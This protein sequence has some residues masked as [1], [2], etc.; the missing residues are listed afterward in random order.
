MPI[1]LARIDDRVIHGQT[2]TRWASMRPVDS[3]IVISDTV[4]DDELRVRVTKSAA[5][6]Y[7]VGIYNVEQGVEALQKVAASNK[8]FFIISDTVSAFAEQARRGADFGTVLNIGN[9]NGHRESAIDLG[10][11]VSMTASE[12]GEFEYL[13]QSGIDLQFQLLPDDPVRSWDAI[14]AK[15][16]ELS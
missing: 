8:D 1:T 12:Y 11:C 10:R 7:K 6:G 4:A 16:N 9:C 2:I 15:Y 14:K 13:A 3:L 5:Q